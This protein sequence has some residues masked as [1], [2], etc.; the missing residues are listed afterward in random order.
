MPDF[1]AEPRFAYHPETPPAQPSVGG[2]WDDPQPDLARARRVFTGQRVLVVGDAI[3][4]C[5]RLADGKS[6]CYAG[7][8]AVI[9]GHLRALGADPHL[10]TLTAPD[11]DS[12]QL[13]RCLDQA[14]VS[15]TA[16]PL[17]CML[18]RR[19]RR[20][21][22]DRIVALP[23]DRSLPEPRPSAGDCVAQQ[24]DLLTPAGGAVI[25]A[26]FGYGT[27]T[28][29][30]LDRLLP[31]LRR[32]VRFLAGDVSGPRVS[33]LAMR[34]FNLLTPTATELRHLVAH[35]EPTAPLDPLAQ[36]LRRDLALQHLLV[37]RDR[38]GCVR[39]DAHGRAHRYASPARG[40]V[41]EVGAGDALLAVASLALGGGL[42][43][44]TATHLGQLAAAAAVAQ[45]GNAPLTWDRL[46]AAAPAPSPARV[47][48]AAPAPATSTPTLPAA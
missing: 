37:T 7:G 6:R 32:R 25:F 10:L 36:R 39:Y 34:R 22:G 17:A 29:L 31:A 3:L 33:L 35:A 38:H 16:L 42:D 1:H 21:Q 20:V 9:A 40:V 26:D 15:H 12:K 45:L 19:V 46:H 2:G 5:Y 18:P 11:Q 47:A 48:P 43:P 30:L 44:D 4:D 24:L 28:A 23:G 27:V 13:R 14:G 8:A 41:D